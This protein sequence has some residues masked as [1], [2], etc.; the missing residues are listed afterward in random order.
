MTLLYFDAPIAFTT[1]D[2]KGLQASAA[3][4]GVHSV[5][6]PRTGWLHSS[7]PTARPA[8]LR[9]Q[10]AAVL[11]GGGSSHYVWA[12]VTQPGAMPGTF[13]CKSTTPIGLCPFGGMMAAGMSIRSSALRGQQA[14]REPPDRTGLLRASPGAAGVAGQDGQD[15]SVGP[16]GAAGATGTAGADGSDGSDGPQGLYTVDIYDTVTTGTTPP[17]PDTGGTIDVSTGTVIVS[18]VNWRDDLPTPGANETLWISRATI[19]PA[20]QSGNIT[21]TWSNPFEAGGNGPRWPKLA[22]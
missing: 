11:L 4:W 5:H 2:G 13:I 8:P 16:A 3:A 18:P 1:A 22:Q 7:G 17:T 19:N 12:L 10:R 9:W 6:Q 21:P 14:R 15:G 20:T